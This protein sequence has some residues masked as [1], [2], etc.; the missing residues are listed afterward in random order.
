VTKEETNKPVNKVQTTKGETKKQWLP[1]F[2]CTLYIKSVIPKSDKAVFKS[3]I[4]GC[5]APRHIMLSVTDP[6]Q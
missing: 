4:S 1:L 2:H 6:Y 5:S 3:D